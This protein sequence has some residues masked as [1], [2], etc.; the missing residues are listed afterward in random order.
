MEPK[1]ESALDHTMAKS[2]LM[3]NL[4]VKKKELLDAKRGW[5]LG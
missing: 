4:L 3:E 5:A 1:L 2:N